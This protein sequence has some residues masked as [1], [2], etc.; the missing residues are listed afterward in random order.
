MCSLKTDGPPENP[1]QFLTPSGERSFYFSKGQ[2][3]VLAFLLKCR[4]SKHNCN[5]FT[6][7]IEF[8]N[9]REQN[10]AF[11]TDIY[12]ETRK[13]ERRESVDGKSKNQIIKIKSSDS[14]RSSVDLPSPLPQETRRGSID[15]I[16]LNTT[17]QLTRRYSYDPPPVRRPSYF[18]IAPTQSLPMPSVTTTTTTTMPSYN[19]DSFYPIPSFQQPPKRRFSDQ[20]VPASRRNSFETRRFSVDTAITELR[21][22]SEEVEHPIGSPVGPV[23]E[24]EQDSRPT[25]QLKI[26]RYFIS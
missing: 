17:N 26:T 25:K 18:E 6:L 22:P 9:C 8:I 13:R 3:T 4:P 20:V 1:V 11:L 14:R 21:R 19:Q 15:E 12:L 24:E 7:R 16:N 23:L 2:E 10:K 5:S